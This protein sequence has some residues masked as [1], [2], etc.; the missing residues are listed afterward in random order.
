[1][2]NHKSAL[3]RERQSRA[4]NLRNRPIIS[5]MRT[6]MRQLRESV[7]AGKSQEDIQSNLVAAV[8]Q[9]N[10]TASKGLIPKK[11][12]SRMISRLNKMVNRA[13]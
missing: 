8:G 11:R 6:R 13:S 4:R 2:A 3:K 9:L 10:R 12:A 1:M 7:E 5:L